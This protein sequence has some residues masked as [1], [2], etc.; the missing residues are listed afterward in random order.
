MHAHSVLSISEYNLKFIEIS[1]HQIHFCSR[2]MLCAVYA[3]ALCFCVCV[4]VYVSVCHKSEFY[5]NS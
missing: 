1:S 3:M 5:K 4:S 2:D